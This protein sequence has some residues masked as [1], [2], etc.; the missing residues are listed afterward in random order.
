MA[1]A[2]CIIKVVRH[3][4]IHN[5]MNDVMIQGSSE[6]QGRCRAVE[7]CTQLLLHTFYKCMGVR[8][9]R[10]V[11]VFSNVART[12]PQLYDASQPQVD[13]WQAQG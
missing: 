1:G 4:K 3:G 8:S 9:Y 5:M 2:S 11:V 10:N 13:M 6:V 7:L 12:R